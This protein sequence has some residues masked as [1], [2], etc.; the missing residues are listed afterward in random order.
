[1]EYHFKKQFP[2]EK[3][4]EDCKET[5]NK[6]P[7]RIPVICEKAPNSKFQT[8]INKTKYLCPIDMTVSQFTFL[9]RQK[10]NLSQG[11]TIYFLTGD[12]VTLTGNQYMSEVYQNHK[13]KEDGFLYITY[14]SEV[15]FG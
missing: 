13:D 10:L 2:L 6:H 14:A 1:M 12:N 4:I 9:I 5:L 11:A 3:R 15:F 7:N 8:T